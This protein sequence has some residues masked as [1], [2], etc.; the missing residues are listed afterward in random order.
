MLSM[1]M[2]QE[3]EMTSTA[4]LRLTQQYHD[5]TD[6]T[7]SCSINVAPSIHALV[8]SLESFENVILTDSGTMLGSSTRERDDGCSEAREMDA[9]CSSR[10]ISVSPGLKTTWT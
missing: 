1:S 10:S 6:V 8:L 7:T 5:E 9:L 2:D 3:I 4:L